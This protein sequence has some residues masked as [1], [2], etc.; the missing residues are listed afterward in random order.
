MADTTCK[1]DIPPGVR[2]SSRRHIE[3][4]VAGEVADV[5]KYSY[6]T[7]GEYTEAL[8]TCV[9]GGGPPIHY[10]RSYAE[11]FEAIEGDQTLQINYDEPMHLKPGEKYSVPKGT[12]HKFS[13]GPGGAKF[14]VRVTPGQPGFEKSIYIL[15]GLARDGWLGTDCLP[16]NPVHT[17]VVGTLGDIYFP[18]AMG[19]VLNGV[20]SV[21]AAYARWSGVQDQ[22]LRRYWE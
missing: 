5:M 21:S 13:A 1:E 9:E 11:H 4:P 17:A 16:K 12:L 18:G 6:E 8:A 20:T 15:F 7:N 22:L 2:D 19:A 3:N 14:K 10:H